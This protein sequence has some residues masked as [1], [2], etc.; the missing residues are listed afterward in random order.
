VPDPPDDRDDIPL[1]AVANDRVVRPGMTLAGIAPEFDEA[2]RRRAIA[3]HYACVTFV[4]AQVG[5][6]L[7]ALDRLKLWDDTIVVLLGDNGFHLGEHGLWRKDTL[8]E[9]S[10]QVPLIIVAPRMEQKGV[11]SREVVE[12][13]DVYPTL[14]DLAGLSRPAG[15]QGSSLLP[16]IANPQARGPGPAFSFRVC[17]SPRLGRTVRTERY[18]FTEWPDGSREMYDLQTD[19]DEATNLARDPRQSA[20]LQDMKKLLDAGPAAAQRGLKA[21][22]DGGR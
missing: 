17:G 7:E 6:V 2:D 12:L 21:S 9:E 11:A 8:F 10:T 16:L 18:R 13:L 20:A 19:P 15:V 3:A 4:D 14:A 22:A 5:V 1:I